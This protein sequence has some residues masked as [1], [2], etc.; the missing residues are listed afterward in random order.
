[1]T[2]P[3]AT[4]PDPIILFKKC[5]ALVVNKNFLF[6]KIQANRTARRRV[7]LQVTQYVIMLTADGQ[8][9]EYGSAKG[10]VDTAQLVYPWIT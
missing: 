5:A 2:N 8:K 6:F 3:D 9:D 4:P 1:M 7:I 10:I